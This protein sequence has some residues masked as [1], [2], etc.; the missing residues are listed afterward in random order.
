MVEAPEGPRTAAVETVTSGATVENK[1]FRLTLGPAG[2]ITGLY[3]KRAARELMAPGTTETFASLAVLNLRGM[4]SG[5][6][7]FSSTDLADTTEPVTIRRGPVATVVEVRRPGGVIGNT[8]ITLPEDAPQIRVR[9]TVSEE[10]LLAMGRSRW[11]TLILTLP[12]SYRTRQFDTRIQLEQTVRGRET[13]EST[14]PAGDWATGAIGWGAHFGDGT[15]GT[16]ISSREVSDIPESFNKEQGEY[17][18][19]RL[20]AMPGFAQLGEEG[21][22]E[23]VI[24]TDSGSTASAPIFRQSLDGAYPLR[25][26]PA[27]TGELMPWEKADDFLHEKAES[28]VT[29]RLAR[30]DRYGAQARARRRPARVCHAPGGDQRKQALARQGDAA[31]GRAHRKPCRPDRAAHTP[32][33]PRAR[34]RHRGPHAQPAAYRALH[35]V[36]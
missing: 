22:C 25:A 35:A 23:F 33:S 9:N 6:P 30:C 3:D 7:R 12:F 24:S 5:A 14:K 16:V 4:R 28:I 29:G 18:T 31:R 32:A 20:A 10:K 8:Q 11:Q 15:H 13:N 36:S 17:A 27:R 21:V 19:V 34:K 1:F 26:V 2:R